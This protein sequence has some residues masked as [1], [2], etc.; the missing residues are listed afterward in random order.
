[1]R[2]APA[3][4]PPAMRSAVWSAILRV[5]SAVRA[6]S[7][8]RR[9]ARPEEALLSLRF[10][11]RS[12]ASTSSA[13]RRAMTTSSE[14]MRRTSA[15]RSSERWCKLALI[16]RARRSAERVRSAVFVR[17]ANPNARSFLAVF[18]IFTTPFASRL[19]SEG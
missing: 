9:R 17:V 12:T 14:L 10:A 13:T 16:E 19:E 8:T 2:R 3:G 7:P 15:S 5:S 11:F 1:M 18:V 6:S 4:M